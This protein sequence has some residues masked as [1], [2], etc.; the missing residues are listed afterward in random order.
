MI[1]RDPQYFS[2]ILN[3]LRH[4][5]LIIE[6]N[7][8]EEGVLEEAEFY[9]LPELIGLIKERIHKRDED[10]QRNVSVVVMDVINYV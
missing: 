2:P 7:L 4:G 3:Y 8:R 10:E 9:N 6:K 5:K 1:D